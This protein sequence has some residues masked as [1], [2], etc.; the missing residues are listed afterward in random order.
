MILYRKNC[1]FCV[2]T[3]VMRHL[4]YLSENDICYHIVSCV[5]YITNLFSDGVSHIILV[6][7][8][9]TESDIDWIAPCIIRAYTSKCAHWY[10]CIGSKCVHI[11]F[12]YTERVKIEYCHKMFSHPT[13]GCLIRLR[14]ALWRFRM[15]FPAMS[16]VQ[17]KINKW[18]STY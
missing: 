11:D 5:L 10:F 8:P 15:G 17:Q 4:I 9:I 16:N 2:L 12:Y 14:W 6:S 13:T 7:V 18:V 3:I 1:F